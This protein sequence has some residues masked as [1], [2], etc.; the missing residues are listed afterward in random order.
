MNH[1]IEGRSRFAS[2]PEQDIVL[3]SVE[4]D[5]PFLVLRGTRTGEAV[6]VMWFPKS[7][8]RQEPSGTD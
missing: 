7:M 1:R 5:H 6:T 3:N 4:F 2:E 8:R